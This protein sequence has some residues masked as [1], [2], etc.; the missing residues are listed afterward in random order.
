MKTKPILFSAPMIRTLLAGRKTQT[1]RV[2]KPQPDAATNSF[3]T[4]EVNAAWQEGFV[5]VK[6]PYGK[7]GDLLWVREAFSWAIIDNDNGRRLL[8]SPQLFKADNMGW[9]EIKWKPSIH[10]P[11]AASRITLEITGVRVEKLRDI[12][13]RDAIA[14]GFKREDDFHDYW[15]EI[16]PVSDQC[17]QGDAEDDP[18]V[19]VIEFKVHQQ[20]V[21]EFLKARAA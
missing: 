20:N 7:P 18:W 5:P 9:Y 8:D 13:E 17:V 19:W 3:C 4:K 14:E 15:F 11:R 12:S 2:I 21:D 16:N 10:M 6:C 1:R